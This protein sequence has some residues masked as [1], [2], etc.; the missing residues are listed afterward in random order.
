MPTP[1]VVTRRLLTYREKNWQLLCQKFHDI[2]Q[3]LCLSQLLAARDTVLTAIYLFV[4]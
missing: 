2:V 4:S 1:I 3:S